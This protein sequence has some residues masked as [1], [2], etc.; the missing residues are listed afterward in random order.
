[1][2]LLEPSEPLTQFQHSLN[3]VVVLLLSAAGTLLGLWNARDCAAIRFGYVATYSYVFA[4]FM[5][6][7]LGVVGLL[8]LIYWRTRWAG[9][10]LIAA[11]LLSYA[12][13]YAGMAVLL[14]ADRVAWRHEPPPVRFGPDVKASAV[15]YFHHGVT[16]EQVEDFAS[17]VLS[18]SARSPQLGRAYPNFVRT[19]LRL[20]PRQANGHEA[21][22]LTFF[23]EA[24]GKA[25]TDYLGK[26]K[27]DSRVET[28]F[29]DTS[30]KD[31]HLSDHP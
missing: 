31:I 1:V 25:I 13:F 5:A 30:P 24:Q 23:R 8:L 26:I 7:G 22:A 9:I 19:Y 12:V 18:Q 11:G 2:P 10:G 4:V 28:V 6:V 27:A 14:R 20:T 3:K 15:I 29:L 16:D 21:I 17:S